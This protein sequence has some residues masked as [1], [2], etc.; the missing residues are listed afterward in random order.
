MKEFTALGGVEAP[1]DLKELKK[2]IGV[3]KRK[4]KA[5]AK[6]AEKKTAPS[7]EEEVLPA[8]LSD[9]ALAEVGAVLDQN[10][11]VEEADEVVITESTPKV[12]IDGVEYYCLAEYCGIENV[13][14]NLDGDI[15]GA[16]DAESSS[17]I[18]LEEDDE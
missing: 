4:A 6:K 2:A 13:L 7:K 8:V 15:I 10:Q 3:L 11:D 17:I 1:T 12:T 18:E 5:A 16:Y 9:A 14:L